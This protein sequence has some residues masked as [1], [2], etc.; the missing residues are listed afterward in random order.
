MSTANIVPVPVR[1]RSKREVALWRDMNSLVDVF[2][3]LREIEAMTG[4]TGLSARVL[5]CVTSILMNA[6][7]VAQEELA[8]KR[9]SGS[10][11]S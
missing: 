5:V 2:R 3:E 4:R 9:N 10:V 11:R 7:K 1:E 8:Q 6:E